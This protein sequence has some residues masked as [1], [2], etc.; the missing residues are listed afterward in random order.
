[1]ETQGT[2]HRGQAAAWLAAVALG[3]GAAACDDGG[4]TGF[5]VGISADRTAGNA[6]L[7]VTFR[8][9][10]NGPLDHE[11]DHT[12]DFGD[13]TTS[14]EAE[15]VHVFEK[16]GTYR[17][18]VLVEDRDGAGSGEDSIE[19]VVSEPAD[20]EV[21]DVGVHPR[22]V[23]AG[24]TV[25]V[26]WG[27]GNAGAEVVGTWDLVVFLGASDAWDPATAT[28]LQRLP[29]ADNESGPARG[30]EI[31]VELPD[32]LASGDYHVGVI[33]DPDEH[34]GDADRA[35]NVGFAPV[36][37]QVRNPRDDGPDLASC[38]V[39][40][41]AFDRLD[42]DETPVAELGDQLA[43]RVCLTNLGNR[44]VARFGYTLFLSP[45][46]VLD[47]DDVPV[48]GREGIALG[49]GDRERSD[50]LVDLA[51]ALGA[52]EWHLLVMVDPD[53]EVAEQ[54][55]DN[56]ERAWP[57]VF[58]LVEPGEVEGVDLVVSAFDVTV[59]GDRVFWGQTLRGALTVTNRGDT[60]VER[61]FV[62][63]VL[64]EPVDGGASVQ[65]ASVNVPRIDA[66]GDEALD[67]PV[68]VTRRVPEGEYRLVAVADP[69]N[70]VGDVNPGNNR[71]VLQRVLTLGGEPNVD[72]AVRQVTFEPGEVEA[73]DRVRVSAVVANAGRDPTG[74]LEAI[75]L[76][77]PLP[78]S[79][80]GAVEVDRFPME[81]LD[82]DESR[83]IQREIT[84]PIELD[85]RV[86]G[87]HVGV[88]VDPDDRLAGELDE[89]N[90]TLFTEGLLT[91][92][93][94]MGG[95]GEDEGFEEND[96]PEQAAALPPGEH[97]ALGLCDGADWYRVEVPAGHRL[98]A[99][100]RWPGE[101][102][103]TLTLADADGEP[104][105]EGEGPA[106][107][108]R[109]FTTAV[110]EPRTLLVGVTGA[111]TAYDL[112]VTVTLADERP[113]LRVRAVAA[114][115]GVVEPGGPVAVSFE[116][117]NVGGGPAAASAAAVHLAVEGAPDAEAVPLGTVDV[118]ALGPGEAASVRGDFAVPADAAE[119]RYFLI[120]LADADGA[121]AEA[122]ED[123]NRASAPLRIDAEQA[124]EADPLEPNRSPVG[125]GG[126]AHAARVPPGEH[127]ELTACG[128]DDDW[129]QI[130][131]E[132]GERLDVAIAFD[133]AAGDLDLELYD[134]DGSTLLDRSAS[135]QGEEAV[136]LLRAPAA[137]RYHV[138]VFL[139]PGAAG[140]VANTYTLTVDV[141][142]AGDCA[143]DPFEPNA[144][145]DGAA[146]LPD[147]VHALTLCPGDED[148]F[149]FNIP[150][151]NTVSF[152][153][154]AGAA[155]VRLAL[156]DPDGRVVEEDGRR[157]VH[158][159]TTSGF[160]RLRVTLEEPVAEAVPYQLTV[161]GVSGVDLVL[162]EVRLSA[163][164]AAP[165]GDVRATVALRNV[166]A[167]AAADVVVRFVLSADERPS[168]DDRLLAEH[169]IDRIG[170]GAELTVRQRMTL[171]A[172]VEPGDW[173]VVV[174]LDPDRRVADLRPGNNRGAAP[175]AVVAACADDDARE[176]EG[177][178][179]ATPLDPEAGAVEGGVLCPYTEDW[180]SLAV[181]RAGTL[182][183]RLAFAHADGDLD[184]YVYDEAGEV[185]LGESR[186]EDD[187][188]TVEIELDAPA[189]V[190][191]RVDGF[192]EAANRYDLSW[193]LP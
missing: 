128:D 127:P 108:R 27:L 47:P 162:D 55:E 123:D 50:D 5:D 21:R 180:F 92:T 1:M 72:A 60:A 160:H 106:G 159:A 154:A 175:L 158:E 121:V 94:A 87:W 80:P 71:R 36:T 37:L 57:G 183:V 143:D 184:L 101:A 109:V 61:F 102:A 144:G 88:V 38:G 190:L 147:G 169:R 7:R 33:A 73:G 39:E 48:G 187:E 29:R 17:V 54:L 139:A 167:D 117:V 51:P 18:H 155:R 75:V 188:E 182:T 96:T 135:L 172:D 40:I 156:F 177:P 133:A 93:G 68:R 119:G 100:V 23:R 170:G 79:G 30:V 78:M 15:P 150:A 163:V 168:A 130:E 142:A 13:G 85:Q 98:D 4:S 10:N 165:G 111:E 174:E 3:L 129:Y 164:E 191:I 116:V 49:P 74:E 153:L 137:G 97:A 186:T 193:V 141:S 89:E 70:G 120:V 8:A 83:P 157:I 77:S 126:P 110:H 166:R 34:V 151:G 31:E 59:E 56:N 41:P 62:V 181:P 84:V 148:W 26:S 52:G 69:T 63:Q 11:F 43:V 45:D 176:N 152:Q 35:D 189:T 136:Q 42:A 179:S 53:D 44:P 12:W 125:G 67:V 171:P 46:D 146:L 113:D 105:A 90:N 66:R 145:A 140:V 178:R 149:R 118:P 99:V 82:G 104:I 20:L 14:D 112:V 25:T 81:S 65:V 138:R 16:A 22:R 173:F 131:L 115:P 2:R 132:E 124:C 28:V 107:E 114:V 19:I 32:D 58:R 76:L 6:P 192:L 64:A 103:L 24:D 134:R 185:A 161:A 95:C 9:S 91:V 122:N 86:R